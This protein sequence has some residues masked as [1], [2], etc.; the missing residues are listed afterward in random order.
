ML[1][2]RFQKISSPHT[3][4]LNEEWTGKPLWVEKNSDKTATM[5]ISSGRSS[6]GLVAEPLQ[7]SPVKINVS[8]DGAKV[9]PALRGRDLG[10]DKSGE[11]FLTVRGAR[12]HEVISHSSNIKNSNSVVTL[13]VSGKGLKLWSLQTVPFC[14]DF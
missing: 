4:V 6:F 7:G 5:K 12:L 1:G 11:T 14:Q 10:E 9:P 13:T 3:L 2:E 8:L